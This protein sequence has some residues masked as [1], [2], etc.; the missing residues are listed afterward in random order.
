MPDALAPPAPARTW[1]ATYPGTPTQL[2]CVRVELRAR[3]ADCPVADDVTALVSELAANALH[4]RSGQPGGTFTVGLSHHPGDHV[5][6]TVT[7]QGS[8]WDCDLTAPANS[9]HGLYL[10]QVLS[11]RCGTSGGPGSRTVWFL[12]HYP[13]PA[14]RPLAAAVP[15]SP[16]A[17]T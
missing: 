1:T 5:R 16:P 11:T 17:R 10:L 8:G 7:D 15:G 14:H 12:I 3:L 9:P 6:A 13:A 4:S 2:A